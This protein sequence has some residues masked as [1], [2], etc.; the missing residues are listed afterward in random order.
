MKL[1]LI[2][3]Y[4]IPSTELYILSINSFSPKFMAFSTNFLVE[5]KVYS[6][7][8][9]VQVYL[10]NYIIF[11]QFLYL[12]IKAPWWDLALSKTK[13]SLSSKSNA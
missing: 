5:E 9:N 8:L 4:E 7:L 1:L 6:Q 10:G 2:A 3:S 11:I 12:F 13:I